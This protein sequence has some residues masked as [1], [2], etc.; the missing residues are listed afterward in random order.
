MSEVTVVEQNEKVLAGV[1]HGSVLLGI[2]TNGLGGIVAALVIWLM[3]REKSAYVAGQALQALVYQTATMVITMMAWC[4]WGVLW[5]VLLLPP[6]FANPEAY[7]NALPSGFWVGLGL[8]IVP[9]A[10]WG[11][12]ILYGLWAA[13]RTLGGHDFRYV[14]IGNWLES[15]K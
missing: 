3:Q 2:F 10:L 6:I 5:T 11:L 4:C 12:S 14:I 13:A 8:M 9:L 7:E 1:A 15:Q